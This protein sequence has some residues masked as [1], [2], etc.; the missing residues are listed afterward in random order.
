MSWYEQIE[1][2]VLTYVKYM[3]EELGYTPRFTSLLDKT[4]VDDNGVPKKLPTVY[5][6]LLQP[7]EVGNDLDNTEIN[8]VLA[9]IEIQIFSNNYNESMSL[10]TITLDCMK[11]LR[12]NVPMLPVT[13]NQ[14]DYFLTVG[15]YRRV[16]GHGDSDLV[17]ES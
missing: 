13:T 17:T 6:H 2:N 9:T 12:F 10:R 11:R 8:G 7:T 5:I 16:I 4:V 15:R 1:P 3:V 14:G